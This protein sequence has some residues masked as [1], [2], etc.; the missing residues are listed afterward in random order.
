[1]IL[2]VIY[3][4]LSVAALGG[5]LGIGLAYASKIFAVKKD[6]RIEELEKA[7]PGANCGAC[8]YAGCAAYAE[9]IVEENAEINLCSPG[10]ASTIKAVAE[11]M[12]LESD[13][14]E[15]EKMVAQVH[16]RGSKATASYLFEYRG[17][18]D[19]NAAH[20]LFEGDKECKFGCL[21]L[22]SCIKVCPTDAIYYDQEGLVRVDREK[23]ISCE[24]CVE[25]CPT[26]V[27]QM[28]PYSAD[29]I[30]ACNSTEKG[31]VVRKYCKVGCIGCKICEKKSPDGGFKVEN[32]L[33][34]IDYSQQGERVSAAKAC[35]PKCIIP[36]DD[37][38]MPAEHEKKNEEKRE[39]KAVNE[40][41]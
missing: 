9:A 31:A 13:V 11:I 16:C 2:R 15:S 3:S 4:F 27:M 37:S 1:M 8:G 20:M 34:T 40:K 29:Y 5:L 17:V 24:K 6:E 26:G 7:L 21:G 33:A 14:G 35:P 18:V 19:C 28:I 23:C 25:V 32:F 39:K 12:G 41:A 38:L 10:G 22:G 30:V 36:A